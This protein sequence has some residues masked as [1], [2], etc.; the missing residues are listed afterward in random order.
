MADDAGMFE[1]AKK[2]MSLP[3]SVK[4]VSGWA[5]KD[6]MTSCKK[7]TFG[8]V[9]PSVRFTSVLHQVANFPVKA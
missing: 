7:G 9:R 3:D 6:W 1:D 2:L 5:P 8:E 4:T